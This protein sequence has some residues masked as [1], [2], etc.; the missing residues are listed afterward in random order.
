M[1]Q[2][3]LHSNQPAFGHCMTQM[4]QKKVRWLKGSKYLTYVQ[5]MAHF[6]QGSHKS[7][8]PAPLQRTFALY[9]SVPVTAEPNLCLSI[10]V[11]EA[12]FIF[13]G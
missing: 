2:S 3:A 9:R 13:C 4:S 1:R 8:Q 7:I 11:G 6:K 12:C 5:V 10:T